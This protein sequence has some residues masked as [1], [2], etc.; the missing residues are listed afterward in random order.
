MSKQIDMLRTLPLFSD[1]PEDQVG[2]LASHSHIRKC[3]RGTFLF[4]HGDDIRNF[5]ILCRG[6]V[7]IFRET[8]DGHEVTSDILIAGDCINAEEVIA[9]QKTH[10]TSARIVDDAQVLEVPINWMR[11]HLAD[12]NRLAPRLLQGLSERLHQAHME[13]EHRSTMSATQMV[14]CYLQGLCVLYEFDPKGFDLPYSK[15]L[16]ASRL[17]MELATFSRTLQKLKDVG[18]SVTGNRVIFTSLNQAGHFVCDN[19]SVSED[20]PTHKALSQRAQPQTADA[21]APVL[22]ITS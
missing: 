13:A 19:C 20:C 8:P 15:T 21:P 12:F 18:I 14:A 5:K 7:Q 9:L 1:L 11:E 2:L 10:L 17:R 22:K 3:E 4:L 6:T 16:I